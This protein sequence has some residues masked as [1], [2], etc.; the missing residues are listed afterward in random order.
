MSELPTLVSISNESPVSRIG[1]ILLAMTV[2]ALIEAAIPLRPRTHSSRAH[3][4]PNLAL[5]LLTLGANLVFTGALVLALAWQ[6]AHGIGLLNVL[7]V[8]PL[9]QLVTVVLVLDLTYYVLH[10]AMHTRPMLWR[11]H[12]VHH[13]DPAV[14]VSTQI[15]PSPP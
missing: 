3:L 15:P 5:T 7:D 8:P 14:D 6:H 13:S 2:L 1:V 11:F 10:V 4:G 9:V 12:R